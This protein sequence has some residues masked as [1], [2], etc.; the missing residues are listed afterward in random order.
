M[1]LSVAGTRNHH[2]RYTAPLHICR[3]QV[4][5]ERVLRCLLCAG[6]SNQARVET[7]GFR[8][9]IEQR[10]LLMMHYVRSLDDDEIVHF[11]YHG[12]VPTK[13]TGRAPG[14]GA[15]EAN[16]EQ[17]KQMLEDED[18]ESAFESRKRLRR[19]KYFL[20]HNPPKMRA[21]P[22]QLHLEVEPEGDN[23]NEAGV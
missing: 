22:A 15:M 21:S 13:R 19:E 14:Y 23:V 9:S 16:F 17:L 10:M 8:T 7:V 2:G 6:S 12:C 4:L 11:A 5:Q 20:H 1:R 18:D 3:L